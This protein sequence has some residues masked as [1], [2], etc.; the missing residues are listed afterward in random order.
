MFY[1][2]SSIWSCICNGTTLLYYFCCLYMAT[3]YWSMD[4]YMDWQK[5]NV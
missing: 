2:Y 1:R 4:H 5:Y 3:V